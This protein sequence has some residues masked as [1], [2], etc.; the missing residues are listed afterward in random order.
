MPATKTAALQS[1]PSHPLST[2]SATTTPTVTTAESG[3]PPLVI[4]TTLTPQT[5]N[6]PT[7]TAASSKLTA[8]T[9]ADASH[10]EDEAI[11]DSARTEML[12]TLLSTFAVITAL[13][14]G[15]VVLFKMIRV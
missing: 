2:D 12:Y 1:S 3:N 4:G 15:G 6:T 7:S 13:A 9:A 14:A 11:D 8:A 5:D 10:S